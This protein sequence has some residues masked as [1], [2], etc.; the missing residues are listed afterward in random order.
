MT[1]TIRD[2]IKAYKLEEVAADKAAKPMAERLRAAAKC[3]RP[4]ASHSESALTRS[5]HA[6]GYGSDRGN[7]KGQPV[8]RVDP[9]RFRSA[10]AHAKPMRQAVPTCLS[11]LT[12]TPSFQG[13][14]DFLVAAAAPARCPSCV[15]ISCTTPIRWPRPALWGP[16]VF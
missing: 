3:S 9:R 12:D 8:Q 4:S 11:V 7:Q 15:K 2:K 6:R 14:K 13:S 1:E 5:R 10:L 16:I